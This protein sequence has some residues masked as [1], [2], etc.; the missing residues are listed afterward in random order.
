MGKTRANVHSA[1]LQPPDRG[2]MIRKPG[3]LM[4]F[5]RVNLAGLPQKG[6]GERLAIGRPPHDG[7]D[8]R[9]LEVSDRQEKPVAGIG[10][11]PRTRFIERAKT[12]G[13][14]AEFMRRPE[15]DQPE[16]LEVSH[17]M[18]HIEKGVVL[19]KLVEVQPRRSFA[20]DDEII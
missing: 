9:Q 18:G 3:L 8:V 16:E 5:S 13:L 14:C 20:I 15:T 6:Q 11:V 19:A 1:A 7:S 10:I 4:S 12:L 2:R 17:E